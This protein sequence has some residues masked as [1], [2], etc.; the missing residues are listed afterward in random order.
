[1]AFDFITIGNYSDCLTRKQAAVYLKVSLP[2]FDILS[3][4]SKS[5]KLSPPLP[6]LRL[7]PNG[8]AYYPKSSLDKWLEIRML[9][10]K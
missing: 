4:Q 10:K 7:K 3:A 6:A 5:G 9:S 1:M 8:R 2:T